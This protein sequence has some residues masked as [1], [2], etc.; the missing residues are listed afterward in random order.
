MRDLAVCFHRIA[1]QKEKRGLR[2]EALAAFRQARQLL[3]KAVHADPNH[4]LYRNDLAVAL[5]DQGQLIQQTR[6]LEALACFA[7]ACRHLEQV[8]RVDPGNLSARINL[9]AALEQRG[10]LQRRAGQLEAAL[11]SLSASRLH[12][13]EVVRV[14]PTDENHR[15][16]ANLL[17]TLAGLQSRLGRHAEAITT[18]RRAVAV[19]FIARQ[20][21]REGPDLT[22]LQPWPDF[23]VLQRGSAAPG[24]VTA[25]SAPGSVRA[26]GE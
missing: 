19:S 6:P 3:E 2:S 17:L 24:G 9:A 20:R 14:R 18:C 15:G 23:Q 26:A 25:A 10:I 11:A 1:S 7:R 13:Q 5:S 8:L 22:P 16:L 21:L 12:Q 4:T